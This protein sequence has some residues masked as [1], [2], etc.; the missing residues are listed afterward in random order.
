MYTQALKKINKGGN[1][2]QKD[3]K[4]EKSIYQVEKIFVWEWGGEENISKLMKIP[5]STNSDSALEYS[6]L[7]Q[8]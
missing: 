3:R 8:S 6:H 7:A 1:E 5:K 4:L 2:Q